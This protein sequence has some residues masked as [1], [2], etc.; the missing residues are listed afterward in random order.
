MPPGEQGSA[1]G[2]G[3]E[4]AGREGVWRAARLARR[5]RRVTVAVPLHLPATPLLVNRS[6]VLKSRKLQKSFLLQ[7]Y[8]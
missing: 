2:L 6:A 8:G 3:R 5:D 7:V 1:R 4:E